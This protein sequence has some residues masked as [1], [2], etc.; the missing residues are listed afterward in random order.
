[1][2]SITVTTSNI[3]ETVTALQIYRQQLI[4][5]AG[6]G[7]YE[8]MTP[9]VEDRVTYPDRESGYTRTGALGIGWLEFGVQL[10]PYEGGISATADNPLVPYV[11]WVQGVPDGYPQA[12]VHVG[13]W[14]PSTSARD[15][16]LP[17]IIDRVQQRIDE[18]GR[19]MFV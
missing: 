18:L 16:F 13:Y 10:T 14:E 3:P 19:E 9:L 4:P 7:L 6:L 17:S 1:M 8:G 12:Q 11:K 15:R 5:T 2:T